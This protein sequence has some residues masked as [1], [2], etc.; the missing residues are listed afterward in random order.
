MLIRRQQPEP[1]AARCD[2]MLIRSSSVSRVGYKRSG[3]RAGLARWRGDLAEVGRE[4]TQHIGDLLANAP[5]DDHPIGTDGRR[6]T[7]M[8]AQAPSTMSAPV[9]VS[10]VRNDRW[11]SAAPVGDPE[12]SMPRHWLPICL[13]PPDRPVQKVLER[14]GQGAG[15][16]WGRDQQC[17]GR[18]NGSPKVG[19]GRM[20]W[21]GVVVRIEERQGAETLVEKGGV[22][23]GA[24]T[25]A[26]RNRAVLVDP[27]RRLPVSMRIRLGAGTIDPG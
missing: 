25:W 21:H 14:P 2:R 7:G 8:W 10:T 24:T 19:D 11:A 6:A 1:A 12:A 15:V 5:I 18:S 22:P 20:H 3:G 26:V 4:D 23:S 16:L 9:Y 27:D 17:I 13:L